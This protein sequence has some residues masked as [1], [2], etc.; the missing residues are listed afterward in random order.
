MAD[1]TGSTRRLGAV[2]RRSRMRRAG[3]SAY[4]LLLLARQ[5]AL[6]GLVLLI[7][8][9]GGRASW[10]AAGEAAARSARGTMTVRDCVRDACTGSFAPSSAGAA[11]RDRVVLKDAVGTKKGELVPV[12]LRPG[13]GEVVHTGAAGWFWACLPLGGALILATVVIAG[14]LRMRRTAWV[15][16]LAGVGVLIGVFVTL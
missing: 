4:G 2:P 8:A 13:T 10:D 9:A 11:A 16:G 1:V 14:G 7:V 3:E 6:V 5:V 15:T 12:A